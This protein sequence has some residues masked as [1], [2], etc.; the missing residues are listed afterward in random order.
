[1]ASPARSSLSGLALLA[2]SW[3]HRSVLAAVTR[4][5]L[6]KRY[7]GSLFGLAWL[8][9]HPMLLLAIYLFVYAVVFKAR[10]PGYEGFDYALFVFAGLVPYIGLSEALGAGTA[11]LKQNMHLVKNVMLPIDLVPVRSVLASLPT[12]MAG[13]GIVAILLAFTGHLSAKVLLLPV[14]LVL[15]VFLLTGLVLFLA[16]LAVALADVS[17]FV[18]LLL[19]LLLFVSPIGYTRDMVPEPFTILVDFN[20]VTYM[21]DAFR[22]VL[23]GAYPASVPS[24][25]VFLALSL[26][27]FAA[28]AAFFSR[29]KDV[30]VDYE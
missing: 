27:V 4:V 21:T 18:N 19:L 13:L 2:L 14:V 24:L 3:R 26:A 23:L 6:E 7:A 11:S 28:G 17:Y 20:P 10:L 8:L 5:E 29:F 1:M 22:A 15:Q 9:L 12:Q 25:L 30:L 16:P